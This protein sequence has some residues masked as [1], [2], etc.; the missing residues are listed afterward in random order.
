MA[1]TT[2]IL[3]LQSFECEK[4]WKS[5]WANSAGDL[6]HDNETGKEWVERRGIFGTHSNIYDRAFLGSKYAS[7][8]NVFESP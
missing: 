3:F 8:I 5:F 1:T 7:A 6:F 4:K 2:Y